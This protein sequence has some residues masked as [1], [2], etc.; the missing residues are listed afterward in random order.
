MD[1]DNKEAEE[2]ARSGIQ[3]HPAGD[4]PQTEQQPSGEENET[5]DEPAADRGNGGDEGVEVICIDVEVP[6]EDV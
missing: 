5:L 4:S 1:V 3:Q 6:T 2:V